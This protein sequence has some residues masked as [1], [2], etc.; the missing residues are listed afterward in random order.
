[1]TYSKSSKK[2]IFLTSSVGVFIL[3]T[4]LSF[5]LSSWRGDENFEVEKPIANSIPEETLPKE[6]TEAEIQKP[7]DGA[8]SKDENLQQ[9]AQINLV[10]NLERNQVILN[11]NMSI[12][13]NIQSINLIKTSSKPEGNGGSFDVSKTNGV[14]YDEKIMPGMR[15]YYE[16]K[17]NVPGGEIFSSVVTVHVPGMVEMSLSD[18]FLTVNG[19]SRSLDT[20]ESVRPYILNGKA[21]VPLKPLVEELGGRVDWIIENNTKSES[22]AILRFRNL[23]MELAAGEFSAVV[24]RVPKPLPMMPVVQNG[25][26]YAPIDI[27]RD[28][29]G[30]RVTIDN[31]ILRIEKPVEEQGT[32][33]G[34]VTTRD[35]SISK[36][37]EFT[38]TLPVYSVDGRRWLYRIN[39]QDTLELINRKHYMDKD[40]VFR[41]D[42]LFKGM[43]PGKT[44]L[45]F[46]YFKQGLGEFTSEE[47]RVYNLEISEN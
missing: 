7:A 45:V 16:L 24:N 44:Q 10:A 29:F 18:N 42:F 39:G 1:M 47:V 43:N 13:E 2:L 12:H 11:W 28:Y 37:Q 27:I 19:I 31:E 5:N 32:S 15:Y 38:I 40:G 4:V 35:V 6:E 23:E 36:G 25:I 8:P 41:N 30:Y 22:A 14:F 17:I 33:S 20:L 3:L 9:L 34:V 46:H 26:F 21:M